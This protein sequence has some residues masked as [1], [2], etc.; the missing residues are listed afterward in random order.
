M[1]AL[2]QIGELQ[3]DTAIWFDTK[4]GTYLLPIKAEIRTKSNLEIDREF[5]MAIWV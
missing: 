2:A 5:E 1:R 4:M 3:W